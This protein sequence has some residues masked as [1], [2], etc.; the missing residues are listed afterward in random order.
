MRL[1]NRPSVALHDVG[2]LTPAASPNA[3]LDHA[4][5]Q[6]RL[7]RAGRD[8]VNE[9]DL[10]RL[11]LAGVH[12][13]D[14]AERL[15]RVLLD[16]FHSAPRALAAR[17]DT[18]RAVAGLS[19]AAIACLKA[20]EG[21]AILSARATLPESFHPQLAHYDNVI[22]YCRTLAGHRDVEEL[23]ALYLNTKNH[24]I[25]DERLQT[26][27]INYTPVYPRQICQRALEVGAAALVIMHPHPSGDARPSPDDVKMTNTLRD[28]LAT[29]GV[30]LHDHVVVSPSDSFS[31]KEKGLL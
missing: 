23:H 13:P 4:E 18:L 28:A 30:D 25:R 27:T 9:Y 22:A 3:A 7:L 1:S 11:V 20:A 31:F 12:P 26:G 21:L 16:T 17:P 2:P 29:I 15:A 14:E 19:I 5:L 8:A 6:D 10:L 24:L